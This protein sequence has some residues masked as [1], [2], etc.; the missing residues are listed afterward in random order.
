MLYIIFEKI[1]QINFTIVKYFL[2]KNI[3]VIELIQISNDKNNIL[4]R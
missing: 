1:M 2:Y 3:T 4:G